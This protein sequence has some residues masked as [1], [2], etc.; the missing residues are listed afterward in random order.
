[1]AEQV[2]GILGV[3]LVAE[4]I[5]T[6]RPRRAAGSEV[7]VG[8]SGDGEIDSKKKGTNHSCRNPYGRNI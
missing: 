8:R 1:M 4:I 5:G 2:G 7:E 3:A 6:L